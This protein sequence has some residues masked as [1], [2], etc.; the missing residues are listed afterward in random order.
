MVIWELAFC[1]EVGDG[2]AWR[3]VAV[4][5]GAHLYATLVRH[6]MGHR[7]VLLSSLRNVIMLRARCAAASGWDE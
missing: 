6:T 2:N 3:K 1:P 5:G 4:G 7:Q